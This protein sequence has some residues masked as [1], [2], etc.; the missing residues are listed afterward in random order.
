[1]MKVIIDKN[2]FNKSI[3][4]AK[5]QLA[6]WLLENNCPCDDT[7]YLQNFNLEMLSWLKSKNI[8]MS[9]NC[10]GNVIDK[11]SNPL[12][13]D[14]FIKNGAVINS[15]A[16][17]SCIRNFSNEILWN[18]LKRTKLQLTLDHYKTAILSENTEVLD[19]IYSKGVKADETIVEIAMKAQKKVSLRW[20][21][22]NDLF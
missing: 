22:K 13:I 9:K 6:D 18:L 3:S 8:A 20:L 4:E 5:L 7:C 16:I 15:E 10:L 19:Y 14:W 11:T 2:I 12:T 21:I 1:M 17:D